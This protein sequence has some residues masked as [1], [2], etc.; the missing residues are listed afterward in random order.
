MDINLQKKKINQKIDLITKLIESL[1]NYNNIEGYTNQKKFTVEISYRRETNNPN[2]YYNVNIL[3]GTNSPKN[4]FNMRF[5]SPENIDLILSNLIEKLTTNESFSHTSFSSN[6]NGYSSYNI[7]LKNNVE[8]KLGIKNQD[9]YDRYNKIEKRFVQ[10][11]IRMT[12]PEK[13]NKSKDVIQEEKMINTIDL[14]HSI[15]NTLE[16]YNSIESYDNKKPFRFNVKNYYDKFK[17]CY[18]YTFLIMR[19]DTKPEIFLTLNASLQNKNIYYNRIY[20]LLSNFKQKESFLIDM[21]SNNYYKGTYTMLTKNSI[22]LEFVF[23]DEIDKNFF[24]NFMN[25]TN[26][27]RTEFDLSQTKNK[28]LNPNE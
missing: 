18:V 13:S 1:S 20:D 25:E 26:A 17:E 16:E 10:K 15:L 11:E 3:R 8:I 28:L 21:T 6:F 24:A 12:S 4:I 27:K 14:M 19:G 23:E 7:N 9:D 5:V 22:S 2:Y